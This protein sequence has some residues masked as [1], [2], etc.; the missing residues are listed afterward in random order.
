MP[1]QLGLLM[2]FQG[3]VEALVSGI[4]FPEPRVGRHE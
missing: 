4:R 1:A 2:L 3:I